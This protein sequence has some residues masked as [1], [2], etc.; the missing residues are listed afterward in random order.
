MVLDKLVD[1]VFGLDNCITRAARKHLGILDRMVEKLPVRNDLVDQPCSSRIFR[2]DEVTRQKIVLCPCGTEQQRPDYS[3]S[4][5][6]N[7]ASSHMRDCEADR[8]STRLN[9]SH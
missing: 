6:S 1:R 9:S 4:V 3:A 7:D 8:K 5:S 2:R